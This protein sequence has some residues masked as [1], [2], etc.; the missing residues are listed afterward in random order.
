M[1]EQSFTWKT[2]PTVDIE[3]V[4]AGKASTFH[5]LAEAFACPRRIRI[6]MPL[7]RRP[8]CR[9][10]RAMIAALR[11]AELASWQATGGDFLRSDRIEFIPS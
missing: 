8:A 4:A 11:E 2:G 1:K 9:T 3:I 6:R 7:P 5:L 10:K